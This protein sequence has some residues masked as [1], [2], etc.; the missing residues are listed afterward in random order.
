M[1]HEATNIEHEYSVIQNEEYIAMQDEPPFSPLADLT[2]SPLVSLP[3]ELLS[4]LL[5]LLDPVELGKLAQTCR[6][7]HA[8]IHTP[9]WGLWKEV[10]GRLGLGR[11][12]VTTKSS[13]DRETGSEGRQVTKTKEEEEREHKG[14]Y[15]NPKEDESPDSSDPP[16]SSRQH[17]L[18]AL[19]ALLTLLVPS[20]TASL[21]NY[22]DKD[23]IQNVR[24]VAGLV[25]RGMIEM[26]TIFHPYLHPDPEQGKEEVDLLAKLEVILGC[27]SSDGDNPY[28]TTATG[29]GSQTGYDA[30]K[31]KAPHALTVSRAYIYSWANYGWETEFGPFRIAVTPESST[32]TA[33]LPFPAPEGPLLPNWAHMRTLRVLFAEDLEEYIKDVEVRHLERLDSLGDVGIRDSS[34]EGSHMGYGKLTE[35]IKDNPTKRLGEDPTTRLNDPLLPSW[36]QITGPWLISFCFVDHRVLMVYNSIPLESNDAFPIESLAEMEVKRDLRVWIEVTGVHHTKEEDDAED[37]SSGDDEV[38]ENKEPKG[39]SEDDEGEEGQGDHDRITKVHFVG[40]MAGVNSTVAGWV[41]KMGDGEIRWHFVSGEAGRAIWSS[42][43]IQLGPLGILG[44]WTTV[45]HDE[46][47]PVGPLWMR[48]DLGALDGMPGP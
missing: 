21:S 39:L 31:W 28:T 16:G 20:G 7:L 40:T 46:G 25:D 43:G 45:F 47:D 41:C 14:K 10:W 36:A 5:L 3:P 42:E 34:G 8:S 6:S 19:D 2:Q 11:V 4:S 1:E 24:W 18:L 27:Y 29:T 12:W 38:E 35:G 37:S 30:P 26:P 15:R 44:T 32:R 23:S 48:R 17:R 9:G 22:H 33:V 13:G